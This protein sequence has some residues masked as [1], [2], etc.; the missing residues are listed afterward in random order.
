MLPPHARERVLRRRHTSPPP[1]HGRLERPTVVLTGTIDP[2]RLDRRQ[3]S[4]AG[5]AIFHPGQL[6]LE[7]QSLWPPCQRRQLEAYGAEHRRLEHEALELFAQHIT[8]P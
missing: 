6:P 4:T 7:E 8:R 5:Q 1:L 2:F 3:L